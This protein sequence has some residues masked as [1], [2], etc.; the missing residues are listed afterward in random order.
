L[1]SRTLLFLRNVEEISWRIEGIGSGIYI[2]DSKAVFENVRRVYVLS[3]V[4]GEKDEGENWLIFERPIEEDHLKVEVAFKIDADEDGE[5][6]RI[7]PVKGSSL[8]VFFPTEKETHLNF[9][10]QGPSEPPP[11][12]ITFPMM[13]S[14]MR[15]WLRR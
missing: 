12:E 7:M 9:L 10:I 1:G 5:E 13:I 4:S 2:R 8:V 11:P 3:K 14:G 15:N 6:E